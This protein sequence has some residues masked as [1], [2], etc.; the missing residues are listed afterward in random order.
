[1]LPTSSHSPGAVRSEGL[2]ARVSH[3]VCEDMPLQ[4]EAGAVPSCGER[5]AQNPLTCQHEADLCSCAPGAAA[6]ATGTAT[7]SARTDFHLNLAMCGV[8]EGRAL[9]P[10]GVF[11]EARCEHGCRP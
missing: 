6:T 8:A 10:G 4:L 7:A 9:R 11:A 3:L 5:L 1:M 2:F